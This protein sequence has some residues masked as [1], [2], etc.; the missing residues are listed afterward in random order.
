MQTLSKH[1]NIVSLFGQFWCSHKATTVL[2]QFIS[3]S[4]M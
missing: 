1:Y 3:L 4:L 2:S